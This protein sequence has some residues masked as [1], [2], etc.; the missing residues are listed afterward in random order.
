MS[1][2]D[3]I[4]LGTGAAGMAAA[5]AAHDAGASV[6]LVERWDRIGG[7]SAISGGV[8]WVADNP[9]MR[10]A[11]MSDSREDALAYFRSLDHGD[12]VPETLEAFVDRGP[13]AL[14]FLEDAGALAVSVLPGYPD[15]YTDRPG[16]KPQGSRALDHDL[17][18]LTT[19][20][21][22]RPWRCWASAW[23]RGNA[24][25]GRRWSRGS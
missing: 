20:A 9:R 3:V 10:A 5:L 22:C 19:R 16:A 21:R 15:Y 13:E 7:T 14:A 6:A 4:I 18:D 8:I 25:S 23:R 12:L 2:V 11:G 17:F 1:E 24:A